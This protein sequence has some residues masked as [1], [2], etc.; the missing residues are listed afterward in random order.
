MQFTLGPSG[1]D[2]YVGIQD[3]MQWHI[4]VGA[5]FQIIFMNSIESRSVREKCSTP[6][7]MFMIMQ[8]HH[9]YK[10]NQK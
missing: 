1:N 9:D 7:F 5:Q 8:S 4:V 6:K 10:R 2:Y 3:S